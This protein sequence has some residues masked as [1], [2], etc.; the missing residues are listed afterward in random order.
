[1]STRTRTATRL[2]TAVLTAGLAL[3]GA[4][5][6]ARPAAQADARWGPVTDLALSQSQSRPAVVVDR[7]GSTTVV[8]RTLEAIIA[9][10]QDAAGVW[11]TPHRLGHGTAPQ[12][13]VDGAGTVTAMW[14]RHLPGFGP[15]VMT[16]RHPLGGHW[17][18]A[19]P[20]SAAV[21]SHGSTFPGAFHADLAV[22]DDGAVLVSWLWG[23]FDSSASRVQARYRPAAGTWHG[24]ATLSPV[25]D[26]GSPVCA[27]GDRGHATVVE[28]ENGRV[29]AVQRSAGAWQPRQQVGKHAEPPQVAMDDGGDATVVWSAFGTDDVFRPQA[30]TRRVGHAWTAPRTL[31]PALDQ[32][33][34]YPEPVVTQGP[35]GHAA[36]AW[37]RPGGQV[38]MVDHPLAGP[39]SQVKQVA[40]AGVPAG[41][42]PPSLGIT[43]GRT[44]SILLTWTRHGPSSR[45][46]EAAYRPTQGS[47]Q[48]PVRLSP[49]GVDAAAAEAFVRPGDRAVAAW[50]GHDTDGDHLQLR[51]LRP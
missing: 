2:A 42:V 3:T 43:V 4:A 49:A 18:S 7:G 38:V 39:W 12:V 25:G 46:V 1:M 17:S 26:A 36:V 29:Y 37:V 51:K 16:A 47:W 23:A 14:T 15:Q 44:G 33:Q 20:V 27:I 48:A 8:W 22:S 9:I 32:P 50:R 35:R 10:R 30:V 40:P 41:L 19:V 45:Y 24:I 6:V 31:D 21:A 5:A 11:G 34:T 13:G 28:V